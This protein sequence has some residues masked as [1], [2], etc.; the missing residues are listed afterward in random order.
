VSARP[1]QL[2]GDEIAAEVTNLS[3]RPFQEVLILSNGFI[4][5]CR[6]RPS[7]LDLPEPKCEHCSKRGDKCEAFHGR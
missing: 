2:D 4:E 5:C 7:G 3:R 6:L 1:P